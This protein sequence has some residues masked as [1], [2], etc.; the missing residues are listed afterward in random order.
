MEL[1]AM[2]DADTLKI[3][4]QFDAMPDDAIV[5]AKVATVLLGG[6]LTEQTLRRN[7]PIP[8]RQISERRFGFRAGDLRK[9]I[10]GELQPAA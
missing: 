7:P 9:L 4:S 5:P 8:K 10:R 3:A 1:S 6:S 2:T